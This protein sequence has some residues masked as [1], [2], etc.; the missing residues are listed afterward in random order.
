[1]QVN[2]AIADVD[3][4]VAVTARAR[5]FSLP[6]IY[7]RDLS[8]LIASL[9]S[10]PINDVEPERD[11]EQTVGCRSDDTVKIGSRGGDGKRRGAPINGG[12]LAVMFGSERS[13][14]T[15]EQLS[16]ANF[17]LHIPSFPGFG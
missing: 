13:G 8:S 6:S 4:V 2:E 5:K 16:T 11:S 10:T 15:T 3:I 1:M 17:L 9:A 7:P 14:L 12:G